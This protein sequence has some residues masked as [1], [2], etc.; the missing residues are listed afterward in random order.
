MSHFLKT[1]K[2]RYFTRQGD[3][4][5]FGA[6]RRIIFIF[7]L[8]VF[9]LSISI[10]SWIKFVQREENIIK[11]PQ[12]TG[13]NIL[14]AT[15][16]IQGRRLSLKIIPVVNNEIPRYNIIQQNPTANT[17]IKEGRTIEVVVSSGQMYSRVPNFISK[18]LNVVKDLFI[19]QRETPGLG[20]LILNGITYAPSDKPI[21]TIIAQTPEAE[22]AISKDN[23][24]V[25]LIVSNGIDH[26]RITLP[27]YTNV[28]FEKAVKELSAL[29]IRVILKSSPSGKENFARVI[30]QEP[31][32]GLKIVPGEELILTIGTG[33]DNKIP[34]KAGLIQ[35]IVPSTEQGKK[36]VL[37]IVI[38]D[39]GDDR[40]VFEGNVSVGEKITEAFMLRGSARIKIFVNN[41][42]IKDELVEQ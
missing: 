33:A 4:L 36:V 22:S 17:S 20:K 2:D 21:N 18:S 31:R 16:L 12:L 40:V 13:L 6:L 28:Y 7:F 38:T 37:K 32:H 29:G 9:L 19:G 1:F 34:H 42:L 3:S 27:N 10:I 35:Y 24:P 30:S 25:R 8:F 23:I 26:N 41:A 15:E 14:D 5:Y 39:A 11:V